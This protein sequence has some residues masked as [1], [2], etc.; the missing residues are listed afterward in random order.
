MPRAAHALALVMVMSAFGCAGPSRPAASSVGSAT[1][2]PA[3]C[4]SVRGFVAA[5]G[6]LL[7][8]QVAGDLTAERPVVVFIHDWAHDST[9]FYQQTAGLRSRFTVV[10]YDLRG[11][12][13][14]TDDAGTGADVAGH[15]K[16]LGAVLDRLATA[17]GDRPVHVVGHGLGGWIA[18]AVAGQAPARLR[19]ITLVGT[20]RTWPA[21]V[22]RA[23]R[24]L[25]DAQREDA[26]SYRGW[27]NRFLP[28]WVGDPTLERRADVI[29]FYDS[30]LDRLAPGS[31]AATVAAVV[32][33]EV[34]KAAL[35]AIGL[36]L[37][38]LNGEL[39]SFPGRRADEQFFASAL[40]ATL[41]RIPNASADAP[42]EAPNTVN[43]ALARF[44]AR[45]K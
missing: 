31:A 29:A 19:S 44:F 45:A 42:F 38:V 6:A 3:T 41:L 39:D 33:H 34:T 8:Y 20:S 26:A 17:T 21:D 14:S 27:T 43:M 1:T 23:Y 32:E 36:P 16:D 22:R 4:P 2:A 7:K 15:A 24:A 40:D 11:H 18:L 5:D 25:A 37:L 28:V 30:M 12:G 35:D 10:T 9:F 13:A